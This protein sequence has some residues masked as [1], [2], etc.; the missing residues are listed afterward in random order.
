MKEDDVMKVI[1]A[2]LLA[3]SDLKPLSHKYLPGNPQVFPTHW[4]GLSRNFNGQ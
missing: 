2:G 3:A 1:V 4:S